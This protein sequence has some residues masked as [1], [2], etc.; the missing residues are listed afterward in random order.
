M[1]FNPMEKMKAAAANKLE[2]AKNKASELKD[3]ALEKGKEGAA[4]VGKKSV[5][6]AKAGFNA[7]KDELKA[8]EDAHIV[9]AADFCGD[10][11]NPVSA[12]IDDCYDADYYKDVE[13]YEPGEREICGECQTPFKDVEQE[14]RVLLDSSDKTH[15]CKK[16][17]FFNDVHYCS[18]ECARQGVEKRYPGAFVTT[19]N[20][21]YRARL[22]AGRK[23]S[24]TE[25]F[26]DKL[27]GKAAASSQKMQ[28][29]RQATE[30]RQERMK[31]NGILEK[32]FPILRLFRK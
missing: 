13:D 19:S 25:T 9:S 5:E 32:L 31:P 16:D 14:Y 27:A 21:E 20:D 22:M 26:A 2:E 10:L 29:R 7:V 23:A 28:E 30:E 8:P 1:G 4:F 24:G 17:T 18:E 12:L 3:A 11:T 6:G 15:P